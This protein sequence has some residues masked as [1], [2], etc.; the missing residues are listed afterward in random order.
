MRRKL[1]LVLVAATAA[2]EAHHSIPSHYDMQKSVRLEGDVVEF[3]YAN[4]HSFVHLDVKDPLSG[5]LARWDI[6]WAPVRRLEQRCVN[7]D[8]LKAGDHVFID[9]YPSRDNIDHRLFL[10]GI[11]RPSD[12]WK[13]G[14]DIR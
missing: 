1:F 3:S 12:G 8:S 11:T 6:E 14:Q 13:S 10:R 4:P 5:Q 2:L 7:K 9:G